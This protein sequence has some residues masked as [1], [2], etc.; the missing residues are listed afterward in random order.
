MDTEL[1]GFAVG[2]LT[3]KHFVPTPQRTTK[4]SAKPTRCVRSQ[5]EFQDSIGGASGRWSRSARFTMLMRA[6][7]AV[8]AQLSGQIDY[9]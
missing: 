9:R 8:D 5:Y 3:G 4:S 6:A 1:P 2:G 7:F